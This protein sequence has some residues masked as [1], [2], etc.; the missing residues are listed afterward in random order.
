[1]VSLY[2]NL[3]V[4][5]QAGTRTLVLLE[6]LAKSVATGH[7]SSELGAR[8]TGQSG[9]THIPSAPGRG[10]AS[11]PTEHHP[12]PPA[13]AASPVSSRPA[14]RHQLPSPPPG[15][16]PAPRPLEQAGRS[17]PR[18]SGAEASPPPYA[19]LRE[20]EEGTGAADTRDSPSGPAA[21]CGRRYLCRPARSERPAASTSVIYLRR[22]RAGRSPQA[23]TP[24]YGP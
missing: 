24:A 17:R 16:S 7:R 5:S 15:C 6:K 9:R 19:G 3:T 13:G 23:A 22:L 8:D 4:S 12:A 14:P 20:R 2:E 18:D 10:R 21:R 1:M 11:V